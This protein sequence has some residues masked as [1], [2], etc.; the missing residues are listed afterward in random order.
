[1]PLSRMLLIA[2]GVASAATLHAQSAGSAEDVARRQ[3]ES[4]RAFARQGNYTEALRDFRTVA[5]SYGLT[6]VAD[7]ALLEIARYYLDIAPDPKE[8]A[9]AV[10]TI[11]KKYPTSNSAPDAYVMAGRLTLTRSHLPADLDAAL[12]NFER[13][14]RLFPFSDAV[15]RS[16]SLAGETL[17]FAGR[18]NDALGSFGRVEVE[19]PISPSAA[20]AYL[21]AGKVL[22]SLG[23]PI[24]AMEEM[25]QVRNRWPGT[26]AA[27]TA[28]AR[29]TLLNRLYLRARS[30]PAFV[31]GTESVGPAKLENVLGLAVTSRDALYYANEAGVGVAT[32][33]AADK[34]P[35][36]AKSRGIT[37]DSTGNPVAIDGGVLRPIAGNALPVLLPKPNG[38]PEAL[39][40]IDAV[41]QL[42]NGDWLVMDGGEK[43]IH[44]FGRGGAYAGPFVTAKV[45]RLAVSPLDEVAGIDR[46]QKGIA[47]FDA[48]GRS[49][50]RIALKGTG[51][52]LQNPE[53]LTYDAFGHLYVLDRTSVAVFSP[54][55]AAPA[56]PAATPAVR[57]ATRSYRLLTLFAEPEKSPTGF[58]KAT[59]FAIASSGTVYLYDDRAQ[60]IMVYR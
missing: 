49:I 6:S 8:A 10:D 43:V 14:P 12:A 52:D 53:D 31:L 18:F 35:A 50:G 16:L 39:T 20:D 30:G 59:A 41:A 22:V 60:R 23:D 33:A 4:G 46:D 38:T 2:C 15:P 25:Q 40:K 42:S 9:A 29:I 28:L 48:T 7:D 1:M 57:A 11:L 44:R 21:G 13:V 47:L 34:F 56:A 54:Y 3:L 26:P 51:Y 17:W 5:D 37:L 24:S 58:H 32:P 19:Y 55:P 27:A 36:V 45:S